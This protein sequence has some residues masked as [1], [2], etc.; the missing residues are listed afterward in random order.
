MENRDEDGLFA[1]SNAIGRV[2]EPY[3]CEDCT[4]YAP[5]ECGCGWGY[6]PEL[7]EFVQR[8]DIDCDLFCGM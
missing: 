2:D 4:C 8:G 6:C 7:G 1:T 5:C 3:R